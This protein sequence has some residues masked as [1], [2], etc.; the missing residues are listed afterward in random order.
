[1]SQPAPPTLDQVRI[2]LAV[3]DSGSFAAAGRRLNRAVSVI[4]YGIGNLEAQLGVR[5]FRRQGTRKPVLTDAG[6]AV[7]AE[8]RTIDAALAGLQAKVAS[9]RAGQEAEV[10]LVVD[11]MVPYPRL[12][13]VLGDFAEAFPHVTLRL[14]METL[15]AVSQM[16]RDGEAVVGLSGPLESVVPGVERQAAGAVPLVTVAAPNHPLARLGTIPPGEASRHVQLVISDRSQ[17]TEGRDFS[18]TGLR[19]WRLADLGAKHALLRQGIGWGNMPL[20]LVEADLMTGT[21]S[22]LDL[23]DHQVDL[24]HFFGVW[25]ADTPPGPAAQWLL[26]R[27]TELGRDDCATAGRG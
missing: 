3:A 21:L 1:M 22:R 2:F 18:V 16:V 6:R 26:D 8:A 20:H 14:H 7:L 23:P 17:A 13:A 5:L 19:T 11:V 25:R 10:D 24:Y 4:S 15:G 9:L 27:F 12:A